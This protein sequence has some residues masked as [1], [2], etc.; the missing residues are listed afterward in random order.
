[1]VVSA[2]CVS[3][4]LLPTEIGNMLRVKT[5]V[6]NPITFISASFVHLGLAHLSN[7]LAV[8]A[9]VTYLLHFIYRWISEQKILHISLLIIFTALPFLYYGIL[10]HYVFYAAEVFGLS[11]VNSGLIGLSMISLTIYFKH[12][13]MKFNA[14]LFITSI[15]FFTFSFINLPTVFRSLSAILSFVYGTLEIKKIWT[16]LIPLWSKDRWEA[17]IIGFTLFFYFISILALFPATIISSQGIVDIFAH[18]FV[19]LFGIFQGG[20]TYFLKSKRNLGSFS[21]L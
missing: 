4:F 7:N 18:Y 17:F 6:F 19:L 1:V 8:F 16:Y 3:I 12:G 13:V 15:I 21:P 11:L 5:Q 9:L 20:I 14:Q 10:V 2:A